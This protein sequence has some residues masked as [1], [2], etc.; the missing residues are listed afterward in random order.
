MTV[1]AELSLRRVAPRDGDAWQGRGERGP[2]QAL[3]RECK[4]LFSFFSSV[5]EEETRCICEYSI[6]L[7]RKRYSGVDG[8]R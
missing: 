2:G 8:W 3:E 6:A 4:Y 1:A 5:L 7:G